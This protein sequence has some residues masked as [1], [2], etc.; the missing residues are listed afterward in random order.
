MK[1]K[2]SYFD[3]VDEYPYYV[4]LRKEGWLFRAKEE[5]SYESDDETR[6]LEFDDIDEIK[7]EKIT[8][9][10][11]IPEGSYKFKIIF[12][13]EVAFDSIEDS[14]CLYFDNEDDALEAAKETL[15][16]GDVIIYECDYAPYVI[17]EVNIVKREVVEFESN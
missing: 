6:A 11:D 4:V 16:D 3:W 9:K 2:K 15:E 8:D 14:D 13:G 17:K 12:R 10:E 7:V 1:K 5:C